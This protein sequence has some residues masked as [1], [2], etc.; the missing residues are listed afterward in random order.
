MKK[1]T[2]VLISVAAST[3]FVAGVPSGAAAGAGTCPLPTY[4]P[5]GPYSPQLDRSGFT[6]DV[7]NPYYPLRPGTTF[8]Y[9]GKKDGQKAIDLVVPTART[10]T[11]DGV[12]TRVVADRLYLDGKL[13]E[14][15]SDYYAQ[16]GCGNVWYFGEDTVEIDPHGRPGSTEG[17]FRAGVNG[18]QP[19]VFMPAAPQ[20]GPWYR[21]EWAAGHAEDRFTVR[22]TSTPVIVP[23]G[24]F[25]HALR[26]EERT[27]LESGVVDNK[28]YERGIGEVEEVTVKGGTEKLVL[29]EVIR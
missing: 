12:P 15:T 19:G 21:Q 5:G 17:S 20:S 13:R 27:R 4:Q 14:K 10:Q 22:S 1:H 8:V 3:L 9:A 7:T 23:A 26:T 28:Y 29:V 16:D 2:Q 25:G 24:R 6:A 11:I 18:A